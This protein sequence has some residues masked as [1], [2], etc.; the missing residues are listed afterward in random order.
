MIR[1]ITIALLFIIPLSSIEAEENNTIE[2]IKK[3]SGVTEKDYGDA[4]AKMTIG[5]FDLYA[6]AVKNSEKVAIS[7]EGLKQAEARKS[8]AFSAFLPK[9]S[10]RASSEIPGSEGKNNGGA[11]AANSVYL[12]GRQPLF[13]GLTEWTSFKESKYN[14]KLNNYLLNYSAA[15]LLYEVSYNF[16]RILQIEKNLESS[17]GILKLYMKNIDELERRARL[18]KSRQS[19]V[20][21]ASSEMHK[22]EAEIVSLN[23]ELDRARLN[24]S[25]ICGTGFDDKSLA[26]DIALDSPADINGNLKKL[27]ESRWDVR[28]ASENIK[29]AGAQLIAAKGGFLPSLYIEGIYRLYQSPD[30]S[31]DYN[32]LFGAEL[33]LFS[34]GNTLAKISEAESKLRQAGL[35]LKQTIRTAEQD[36]IDSYQT[37]KNSGK[38]VDAYRKALEWAEENYKTTLRDYYLNLL[39]ILDVT[40]SLKSLQSAKSDYDRV[41]LQNKFNRI[42]LAISINEITGDNINKIKSGIKN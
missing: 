26:D 36:I 2:Q 6:L 25:S 17:T 8:Q 35:E 39:T 1:Y 9:I 10:L 5:L 40:T 18:G 20:L 21:T 38:E 16:Y 29:I 37:W 24:I 3:A 13:T 31:S 23:N 33:P 14:L 12:Y 28:I 27:V 34:G 7:G 42:L 11:S 22:L 15:Q 30:T 32:V 41:I 19:E 4:A